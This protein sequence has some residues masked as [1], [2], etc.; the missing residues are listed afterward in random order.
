MTDIGELV[1]RAVA[2]PV[3]LT[4]ARARTWRT[5]TVLPAGVG[6]DR[7][8]DRDEFLGEEAAHDLASAS[9]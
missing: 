4:S 2:P 1:K 3:A 7:G 5:F 6:A 9:L 8:D